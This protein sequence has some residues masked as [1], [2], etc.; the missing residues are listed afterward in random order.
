MKCSLIKHKETEAVIYCTKCEKYMCKKCELIH[1]DF[2]ESKHCSFLIKPNNF[3]EIQSLKDKKN[4]EINKSSASAKN[5]K[6]LENFFNDLNEL[7]NNLK[8]E[9]EKINKKKED[10]EI[11]IQNIF[12]KIRNE[13]NKVEDEYLDAINN[14]YNEINL[15]KKIKENEILLNK[16]KSATNNKIVQNSLIEECKNI[17][18][19]KENSENY[20]KLFDTEIPEEKYF[21]DL[22]EKIKNL[23]I[24]NDLIFSSSIIKND[25][26]K[27][28]MI[29]NWIKEKIGANKIKYELI[30]Q[31][32]KNGYKSED[33]H[34]CCDFKGATLTIIETKSKHIFGGFTPLSWNSNGKAYY[35]YN[36]ETFLFSMNLMKKYDM[37]NMDKSAI[38]CH[39]DYGPSFGNYYGSV[40]F[41]PVY[42]ICFKKDLSRGLVT[43]ERGSNFFE[44]GKLELTDGKGPEEAFVTKEIEIFKVIFE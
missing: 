2:F 6:Y 31:M 41:G 10:L 29:N 33:F 40:D 9:L 44:A 13:L 5:I 25:I 7:N 36:K 20:D 21:D 22:I 16:I 30:Y 19:K 38:Y 42:D 17:D 12:T 15:D 43:A 35:D 3:N 34:K 8:N 24:N 37:F 18:I 1:S 11:N 26:K 23:H 14:N 39:K 28:N 4:D 27:Q 32:S